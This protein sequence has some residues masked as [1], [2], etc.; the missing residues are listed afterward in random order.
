MDTQ[1]RPCWRLLS[2]TRTFGSLFPNPET[3]SLLNG[4]API[5]CRN[6]ERTRAPWGRPEHANCAHAC[7]GE[8]GRQTSKSAQELG[9]AVR[10]VSAPLRHA[11]AFPH[12]EGLGRS[13]SGGATFSPGSLRQACWDAPSPRHGCLLG[14][15][16]PASP[17][18]GPD[19]PDPVSSCQRKA[20][21]GVRA[22]P[23]SA[24]PVVTQPSA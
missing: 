7:P 24:R 17:H 12:C 18:R 4:N 19:S 1:L 15:F 23:S 21:S 13:P 14:P 6:G 22:E 2:P 16:P 8:K 5:F 20:G 11:G 10:Q 3:Q 9:F